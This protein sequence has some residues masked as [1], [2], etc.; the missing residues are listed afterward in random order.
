MQL[1]IALGAVTCEID[2]RRK[3]RRAVKAASRRN[4]LHQPR[5][6]RAGYVDRRTGTVRLR[7]VL[8]GTAAIAVGIHV[9]LLSVLAIAVHG[10]K[11]L[12]H[13]GVAT[14][15]AKPTKSPGDK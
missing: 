8:S 14:F 1:R 5:K 6:P 12:R 4:M 2:I 3:G 10:E 9:A 7:A 13:L 11:W 15:F